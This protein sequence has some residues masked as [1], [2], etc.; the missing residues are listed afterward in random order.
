[1]G[2]WQKYKAFIK[3][4]LALPKKILSPLTGSDN[5]ELDT[6]VDPSSFPIEVMTDE[7]DLFGELTVPTQKQGAI[8]SQSG[9]KI[10]GDT[11]SRTTSSGTV[12]EESYEDY[13][14]R[15][16]IREDTIV[17]GVMLDDSRNA[18]VLAE[19]N[20]NPERTI[21]ISLSDVTDVRKEALN[22]KNPGIV[23]ET[24]DDVYKIAIHVHNKIIE[25][26]SKFDSSWVDG[27]IDAIRTQSNKLASE[28]G[29]DA[30]SIDQLERLKSLHDDGALSDEEF[31]EKKADILE[32]M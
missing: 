26:S 1:M 18:K 28:E 22:R 3:W 19:R 24:E 5:T 20:E 30:D 9:W 12:E 32:E 10:G 8:I 2:L 16:E 6:D 17:M 7:N 21:R 15:L 29:G 27:V 31:E 14:S 23:F 25:D 4:Q 11:I 13:I